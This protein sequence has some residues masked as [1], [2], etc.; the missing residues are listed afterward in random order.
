MPFCPKCK[1][2]YRPGIKMC[3]D[4]KVELVDDLNNAP[5]ALARG[6]EE[7]LKEIQAFLNTNGL[8]STFITYDKVRDTHELYAD[9]KDVEKAAGLLQ[10]FQAKKQMEYLSEKYE[11]PMDEMTPERAKELMEQEMEEA[12]EAQK[13]AKGKG[14]AAK[15][16]YVDKR[17]RAEEYKS[18]GYVL[19]IVGII[20]LLVLIGMYTGMIPGFESLR[21]NYMF[22]GVMGALFIVFIV[23]GLMSFTKIKSIIGQAEAD[24]DMSAKVKAL[25]EEKLTKAILDKIASGGAEEE[26]FFQRAEYMEREIKKEFPDIDDAFCE[27][28]IDERYSELYED[29]NR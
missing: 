2:E 21:T 12:K 26:L 7:S 9:K 15:N 23:V 3:S 20:G 25:M 24:E 18:S 16:S 4:C 6:I 27:K 8:Q 5:V 29:N 1:N 10:V 13:S 22:L 14:V 28:L 11:I 19:T 17:Q